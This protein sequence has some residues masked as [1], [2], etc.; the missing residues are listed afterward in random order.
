MCDNFPW[1]RPD[2]FVVGGDR[3]SKWASSNRGKTKNNTNMDTKTKTKTQT[4]RLGSGLI[5]LLL[6]VI[7]VQNG[8]PAT[9]R[10]Q[11]QIQTAK[12]NMGTKTRENTETKTRS[13][14]SSVMGLL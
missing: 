2:G 13:L 5:A 3:G 10:R 14:G 6:E 7:G 1:Q 4:K 8:H 9:E 12:A 11:R